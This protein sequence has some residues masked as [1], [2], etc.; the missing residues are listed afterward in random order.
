MSAGKATFIAGIVIGA[1]TGF[2]SGHLTVWKRSD[3]AT[4]AP[5]HRDAAAWASEDLN[6]V[7][8]TID[9]WTPLSDPRRTAD[10]YY[11]PASNVPDHTRLA[12]QPIDITPENDRAAPPTFLPPT[13]ASPIGTGV[14]VDLHSMLDREAPELSESEREVWLDVLDGLGEEDAVGIVRMWKLHGSEWPPS[15][16]PSLGGLDGTLSDLG[17]ASPE[18]LPPN[19]A[20]SDAG[21]PV[22]GSDVFDELRR[23]TLHNLANAQ[24]PGFR[25]LRPIISDAA[26]GEPPGESVANYGIRLERLAI[27]IAEGQ[28]IETGDH[29][30]VAIRSQSNAFLQVEHDG[31]I[32]VT[33]YGQ[34]QLDAERRLCI[35]AHGESWHLV[36]EVVVPE[37]ASMVRIDRDG[38]VHVRS[39]GDDEMTSIGRIEI[40]QIRSVQ[41]LESIG[42]RLY[43]IHDE[44]GLAMRSAHE[45]ELI[46][47]HLE[48]SNVDPSIERGRMAW[49]QELQSLQR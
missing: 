36:P 41:S 29:W 8:P 28:L 33:R 42:D 22:A 47:Y 44:N 7:L 13:D 34:L 43:Q 39:V 26:F 9:F 4:N 16:G 15:M 5:D 18:Q 14:V 25:A 24:T 37:P 45:Y 31:Q 6:P 21:L 40:W 3:P 49:M 32:A 17:S 20:A 27:D 46:Q 1:T 19:A 48:G 11:A 2:V 23:I 10:V 38:S 12:A 35:S 30:D